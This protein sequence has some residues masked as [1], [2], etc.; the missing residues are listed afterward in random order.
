[1]PPSFILASLGRPQSVPVRIVG[2]IQNL[3]S[4]SAPAPSCGLGR[5]GRIKTTHITPYTWLWAMANRL[6]QTDVTVTRYTLA[7]C[8]RPSAIS[9][10]YHVACCTLHLAP[11]SCAP[12]SRDL[13]LPYAI[14]GLELFS[15]IQDFN[16]SRGQLSTRPP[17]CPPLVPFVNPCARCASAKVS[18]RPC[19]LPI[20]CYGYTLWSRGPVVS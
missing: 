9:Q 14:V 18:T 15:A 16:V 3:L 2:R 10:T 11:S 17:Q 4:V 6:F 7:I 5:V 12:W 1:V 20:L 13:Q 19:T 8:D